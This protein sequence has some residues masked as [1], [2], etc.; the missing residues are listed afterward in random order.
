MAEVKDKQAFVEFRF[1]EA[2][3]F[4]LNILNERLDKFSSLEAQVL[5]VKNALSA[6]IKK[7][8]MDMIEK[9]K[10]PFYLYSGKILQNYQQGLGIFIDMQENTNRIK[11]LTDKESDHDIIHHLSSGQLAVVSIA[12]C[13]ALNKV[14]ET[15]NHFKFLAIDDPVQTLDD[16]N[17][18]SF[19]ELVRHNF[20]DYQIVMSTHE[21]DIAGYL[22]YKFQKFGFVCRTIKVQQVFYGTPSSLESDDEHQ[23]GENS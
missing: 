1:N 11:F 8:K 3:L 15:S 20:G 21:D 13:L 10:M 7:Y 23:T 12:F 17:I 14:Y 19:I 16:I 22:A 2:R 18:H 5:K 4:S 9:I 6:S